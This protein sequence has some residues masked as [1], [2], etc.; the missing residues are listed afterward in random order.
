M[1]TRLRMLGNALAPMPFGFL[2]DHGLG[3]TVM[4]LAAVLLVAS[5]QIFS[6]GRRHLPVASKLRASHSP[7][8]R[9]PLRQMLLICTRQIKSGHGRARHT[10]LTPTPNLRHIG[11][12][13]CSMLQEISEYSICKLSQSGC[14]PSIISV[15]IASFEKCDNRVRV[16]PRAEAPQ[17]STLD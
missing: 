5:T 15:S 3:M 10:R 16:K 12:I 4:A 8:D 11:R 9:E 7:G 2:M 17:C 1:C 14:N 6:L 13:S